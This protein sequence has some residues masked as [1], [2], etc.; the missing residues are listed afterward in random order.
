MPRVPFPHVLQVNYGKE[1]VVARIVTDVSLRAKDEFD[2]VQM[3]NGGT[4]DI[5]IVK[6]LEKRKAKGD[7][8]AW[9]T[10]PFHYECEVNFR[11][12]TAENTGK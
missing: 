11:I 5:T 6:V 10:K 4:A 7:W 1:A 8:S 3:P 9:D 12:P 2:R